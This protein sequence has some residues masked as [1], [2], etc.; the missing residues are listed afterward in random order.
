MH[1]YIAPRKD[2]LR[3]LQKNHDV[4]FDLL[5][6]IYRGLDGYF[7]RMESLLSGHAFHKTIIQLVIHMRRFSKHVVADDVHQT[8]L[9]HAQLASLAGLSRETVTREI[10]KLQ[11]KKLLIYKGQTIIV[12]DI[13][14]LEQ[15]LL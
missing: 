3:F 4:A 9:T 2:V 14:A 15:E 1:A 6:R 5:Q 13:D 11:A 10:K 8:K 12:P 7:L